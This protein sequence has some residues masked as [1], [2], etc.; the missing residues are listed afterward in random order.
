M[1]KRITICPPVGFVVWVQYSWKPARSCV[2]PVC[3]LSPT[4]ILTIT[5]HTGLA[6]GSGLLFWFLHQDVS[7]LRTET[8][9]YSL[10]LLCL[11]QSRSEYI[12]LVRIYK[13]EDKID[14]WSGNIIIPISAPQEG[15][16]IHLLNWLYYIESNLVIDYSRA[17][18]KKMDILKF[19][20]KIKSSSPSVTLW[21]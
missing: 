12:T 16:N 1:I 13:I 7:S 2:L 3:A 4:R 14:R 20:V 11:M 8:L 6:C 9:T 18:L 15:K 19:L 21:L 17:S 10:Y 5:A